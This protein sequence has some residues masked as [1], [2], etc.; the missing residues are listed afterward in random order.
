[1]TF[2]IVGLE[3][4]AFQPLFTMSDAE[5]R[6]VHAVMRVADASPGFPC[7][8]SLEDAKVDEEVLLVM[9]EHHAVDSP[10]RASG[11]IYVRR[12]AQ[13]AHSS[14]DRVPE[15]LMRRLLSVRA[16]DRAGMMR[17]AEVV[18]GVVLGDTI[19]HLFEDD[20]VLYLHVHNA[21]PGCFACRVERS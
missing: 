4:E 3:P 7:R 2:R 10:Y 18:E 9:Y 13:R 15:M 12:A 19:A 20:R 5:R 1:M 16:Y 6:G 21:K 14:I 17:A 8:V 11:P